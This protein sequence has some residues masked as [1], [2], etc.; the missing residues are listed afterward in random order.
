MNPRQV[1]IHVAKSLPMATAQRIANYLGVSLPTLY[2][3]VL[4]YHGMQFHQ[5]SRKYVCAG[6]KCIVVDFSEADYGWRY[7]ITDRIEGKS[8]GCM[9]FIRGCDHLLMTTLPPDSDGLEAALNAS[10]VLNK[11]TGI[12]H[13]RYPFRLPIYQGNGDD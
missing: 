4:R 13:L 2:S 11:Q 5:F 6:R 10:V 7:T 3:W 1:L 8:G 9:C 12:H